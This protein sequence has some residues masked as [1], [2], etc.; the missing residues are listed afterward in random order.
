VISRRR[1]RAH[2]PTR[3]EPRALPWQQQRGAT[4]NTCISSGLAVLKL[5]TRS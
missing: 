4:F 1:L 5:S 2:G 3:V